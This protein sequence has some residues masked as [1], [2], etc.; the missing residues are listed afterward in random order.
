MRGDD[1]CDGGMFSVSR[2]HG[3]RT[4]RVVGALDRKRQRLLVGLCP[5]FEVPQLALPGEQRVGIVGVW[6]GRQ[7]ASN[8][9][10]RAFDRGLVA[11]DCR[12]GFFAVGFDADHR[13]ASANA[14]AAVTAAGE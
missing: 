10:G 1:F 14:R 2:P 11:L 3:I 5:V 7:M 4:S 8:P 12:D 13:A 6:L 9:F